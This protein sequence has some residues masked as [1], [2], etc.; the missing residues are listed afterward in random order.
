MLFS[1]TEDG[2]KSAQRLEKRWD[3][4]E[5]PHSGSGNK[6]SGFSSL[7]QERSGTL[8][9]LAAKLLAPSQIQAHFKS[10]WLLVSSDPGYLTGFPCVASSQASRA[11]SGPAQAGRTN[12]TVLNSQKCQSPARHSGPGVLLPGPSKGFMGVYVTL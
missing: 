6:N 7:L 8:S 12:P 3:G 1:F 9:G 10:Y 11:S 5:A 4:R 2:G